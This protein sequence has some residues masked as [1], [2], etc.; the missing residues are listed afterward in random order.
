MK[1]AAT[2]AK[3][4][5]RQV[6]QGAQQLGGLSAGAPNIEQRWNGLLEHQPKD[7]LDGIEGRGFSKLLGTV[8]ATRMRVET[9]LML[10]RGRTTE[11]NELEVYSNKL[12]AHATVNAILEVHKSI[13]DLQTIVEALYDVHAPGKRAPTLQDS[14]YFAE[15]EDLDSLEDEG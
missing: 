8:H 13:D 7:F 15:P 5:R 9:I 4:S 11:Q 1:K 3:D 10:Y 6:R 12:Q 2:D 14:R